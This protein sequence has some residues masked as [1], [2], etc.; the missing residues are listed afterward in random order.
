MAGK[1]LISFGKWNANVWSPDFWIDAARAVLSPSV[2]FIDN[3]FWNYY[4]GS[5]FIS[6]MPPAEGAS[7]LLKLPQ[8][9]Q[10]QPV[11]PGAV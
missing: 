3:V 7:A 11:H 6:P 10:F 5:G 4:V 9:R 1:M 2:D 8:L